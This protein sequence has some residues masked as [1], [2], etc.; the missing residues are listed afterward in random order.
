MKSMTSGMMIVLLAWMAGAQNA[1][2]PAPAAPVAP[3]VAP[4]IAPSIAPIPPSPAAAAPRDDAAASSGTVAPAGEAGVAAAAPARDPAKCIIAHFNFDNNLQSDSSIGARIPVTFKRISSA[5]A[6]GCAVNENAPRYVEGKFGKA[7]LLESAY[8]NLFSSAQAGAGE[9][10]AFTPLQ[11]AALSITAEL[12]W[13]GKEALAV[14]TKGENAEEG[15]SVQAAVEKAFYSKESVTGPPAIV[16][17]CYV[18]SLYLKGQGNV[19]IALKDAATGESSEP[20]YVDLPSD[21]QRFS[22]VFKYKFTRINIGDKKDDNWKQSMPTGTVLEAKLDLICTTVDSAKLNF[23]ADGLQLE[24]RQLVSEKSREMSP[25]SWCPGAFKTAQD[26]FSISLRET[27]F[28]DWKKNGSLA[29]WFKPNW[30]ARDGSAELI[31]HIAKNQLFL[32]HAAHQIKFYPAGTA[33]TPSDLKNS[34]H[35]LVMTWSETGERVFYVDGMEY[36]N[37]NGELKPLVAAESVIAGDFAKNLS[38]NAAIDELTL[39]DTKLTSEQAQAL[40]TAEPPPSQAP[41]AQTVDQPAVATSSTPAESAV[42]PAPSA[43]Q[44]AAKD[45]KETDEEDEEEDQDSTASGAKPK[46]GS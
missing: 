42:I 19:K 36:P 6:D 32:V 4:V 24:Q 15:F 10:A 37:A 1:P 40:A 30:E 33:F 22:C 21:W 11:N 8:A 38:P 41:A 9:V 7:L 26:Q 12:P 46:P 44:P 45:A 17:A 35:H 23:F 18:A 3:V 31:F 2:T 28:K 29:C 43:S 20:V 27:F 14:A 5:Y 34:W 25:H 13:Q 16:P 39:Y